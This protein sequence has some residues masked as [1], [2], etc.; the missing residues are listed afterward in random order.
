M[1]KAAVDLPPP[2]IP[3]NRIALSSDIGTGRMGPVETK[4]LEEYA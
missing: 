4:I 2:L 3:V 1:A